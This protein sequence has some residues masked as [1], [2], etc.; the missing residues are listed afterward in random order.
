[1]NDQPKTFL[2]VVSDTIRRRYYSDRTAKTDLHM[3]TEL[4]LKSIVLLN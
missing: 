1:M 4:M 3:D 2:E